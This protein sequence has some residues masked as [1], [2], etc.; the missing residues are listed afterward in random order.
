MK[1]LQNRDRRMRGNNERKITKGK[2]NLSSRRGD[3]RAH[4]HTMKNISSRSSSRRQTLRE[5]EK[6]AATEEG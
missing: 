6:G 4:Q 2:E 1:L 5:K 3:R